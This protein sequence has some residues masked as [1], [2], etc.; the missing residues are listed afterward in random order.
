MI[1]NHQRNGALEAVE[2]IVNRGDEN[3]VAEVLA[4]LSRIYE[5]VELGDDGTISAEG[6][7]EEDAAFLERVTILISAHVP[8]GE[9][10]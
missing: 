2:R 5:S 8:S 7:T 3:V 6:S 4:L 10:G 1:G 9:D